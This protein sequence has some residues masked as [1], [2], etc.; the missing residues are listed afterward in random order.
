MSS[1]FRIAGLVLN[2]P[3]MVYPPKLAQ[4]AAAL[5]GRI[6]I[7]PVALPDASTVDGNA[8]QLGTFELSRARGSSGEPKPYRTTPEGVAIVPIFGSLINRGG[9]I[10]AASGV[11]TYQKLK[12]QIGSAAADDDVFAIVLDI[13]SSGGEC[14]GSFEVADVVRDAAKLKQVYAV[15]N[16]LCCSA[17]FLIASAATRVITTQSSIVGSVGVC[18]LHADYSNKLHQAGIV[19]TMIFAGA[20]KVDGNP[21][22]KLSPEVKGELKAE[23]DRF[24]E[25]FI[26][27]VASG[28]KGMTKAAVRA[29]QAR[30]FI[31][32]DAVAIGFADA[33]GTLESVVGVLSKQAK[34]RP[35]KRRGGASSSLLQVALASEAAVAGAIDRVTAILTSDE[36]RGLEKASGHVGAHAC[37]K[38]R[39]RRSDRN[40]VDRKETIE[41]P[42]RQPCGRLRIR[43][44]VGTHW[45]AGPSWKLGYGAEEGRNENLRKGKRCLERAARNRNLNR[46]AANW[47]RPKP[48][49]RML[50]GR[51]T[52]R[53]PMRSHTL[54]GRR[55]ALRPRTK[56]S[57]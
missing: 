26:A 5:A 17:A 8:P 34:D 44:G 6:G 57:G 55:P 3:L 20:R 21:Y 1:L 31:G 47:R 9:W 38:H 40:F 29:T 22:E 7:E 28:R 50:R 24:Y 53:W 42:I 30:T 27:G 51:K 25:L 32:A 54:R 39:H 19:P 33:V 23:I 14:V 37:R 13:D 35:N 56:L 49:P 12:H 10:D 46:R 48:P 45:Y 41:F 18:M 11:T 52:L 16:G 36:A 15:A 43:T 4:I 2:R